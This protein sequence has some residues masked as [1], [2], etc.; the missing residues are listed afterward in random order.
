M[1]YIHAEI[2]KLITTITEGSYAVYNDSWNNTR[3]ILLECYN[4]PEDQMM[5]ARAQVQKAY[6]GR[7][8]Y[9][10]NEADRAGM[11]RV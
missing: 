4:V 3:R 7:V 8:V 9:V 5:A 11:A 10:T 1:A 2:K 6:P